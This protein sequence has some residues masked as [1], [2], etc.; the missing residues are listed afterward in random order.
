[1]LLL[2]NVH[3]GALQGIAKSASWNWRKLSDWPAM[4]QSMVNMSILGYK[5]K[6]MTFLNYPYHVYTIQQSLVRIS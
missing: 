3:L 4:V 1:M 2:T 6:R 5:W